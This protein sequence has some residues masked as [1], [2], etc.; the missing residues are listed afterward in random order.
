MS[1]S[2]G[3][4]YICTFLL[5]RVLAVWSWP[6]SSSKATLP[7]STS[8]NA[9]IRFSPTTKAIET[10]L[11]TVSLF[12]VTLTYSILMTYTAYFSTTSRLPFKSLEKNI[13][14]LLAAS[15]PDRSIDSGLLPP[16]TS[17]NEKSKI[18]LL[19]VGRMKEGN[20]SRIARG[21]V[22]CEAIPVNR[23]ETPPF[24]ITNG[25]LLTR[26]VV[27]LA[28]WEWMGMWL[29]MI[30]IYT[31]LSFNGFV[32]GTRSHDSGPRALVVSAYFVAYVCH[33]FYVRRR[34]LQ[35]FTLVLA[36]AAWSILNRAKF[37]VVDHSE[38]DNH[39]K[40]RHSNGQAAGDQ[41][42]LQGTGL[43]FKEIEK[44]STAHDYTAQHY[45]ASLPG[46]AVFAEPKLS[47]DKQKEMENYLKTMNA[48]QDRERGS[49]VDSANEARKLII[50]NDI[51]MMG[52]GLSTTFSTWTAPSLVDNTSTQIGSLAL[53]TTVIGGLTS[54]VKS[55]SHLREMND[56]FN[57]ILNFKEIKINGLAADFVQKRKIKQRSI[58]FTE[59]SLTAHYVTWFQLSRHMKWL[60]LIP[61]LLFGPAYALLPS[62][63]DAKQKSDEIAFELKVN[64]R[65]HS[66]IFTTESTNRHEKKEEEN[67]EAINVCYQPPVEPT[68]AD[69]RQTA[70]SKS[71]NSDTSLTR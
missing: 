56:S 58:G 28:I 71:S 3:G 46:S 24:W 29:A 32:S 66:V 45:T 34:F 59:G 17:E 61:L 67:I 25:S 62:G 12:L 30:M 1:S 19:Y 41:T 2:L 48:W 36:G 38:L 37:A 5:L 7:T 9:T 68:Q 16:E 20:E 64:V 57:H 33:F 65:N 18:R 43:I 47:E 51:L 6:V 15:W 26:S 40:E 60:E 22:E 55:T 27:S 53:L 10:T 39:I 23:A 14:T 31:T 69:Q 50:A 8:K 42:A 44:A 52:I 54:L 11:S 21:I 70:H 13:G 4:L 49:A 35:F 63:A